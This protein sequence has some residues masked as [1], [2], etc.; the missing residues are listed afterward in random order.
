MLSIPDLEGLGTSTA[1]ICQLAETALGVDGVRSIV[2]QINGECPVF[3]SA[4]GGAGCYLLSLKGAEVVWTD[5]SAKVAEPSLEA[6]RGE[7]AAASSPNVYTDFWPTSYNFRKVFLSVACHD[8]NDNVPGGPCLPNYGCG[9]FNENWHSRQWAFEATLGTSHGSAGYNN[10]LERGYAVRIGEGT[11]GNNIANSNSWTGYWRT[12]MHLPLHSN[13]GV[14]SCG[15]TGDP[16]KYGTHILWESTNGEDAAVETH[17]TMRY[18]S[19]GTNDK[20][21]ERHD[22]GELDPNGVEAVPNYYE[23]DFH[24]W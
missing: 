15:G 7:M 12:A 23:T 21:V 17:Y 24:T 2:F 6:A 19:P 4:M 22:L 5:I 14:D 10:L 16:A 20:P 13:A 8:G 3:W 18:A 1:V 9:G 11:V